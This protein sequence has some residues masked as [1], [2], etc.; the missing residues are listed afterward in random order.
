MNIPTF[1][2]TPA[3]SD[4]DTQLK[5]H[6]D[7]K[8]KP[9]GALG[10]LESIA[11]KIGRIQHTLTPTLRNPHIVVFAG[12]HGISNSGVS[13]Y[14]QEVT[15]QMV[16]NFL[17]NGAAIN[18][19]TNQ[20]NIDFTV[21]DAGVN[22]DFGT[23]SDTRFVSKK[24]G[25]GTHNY[26]ETPAMSKNELA[27]A[28][29]AGAEI[30][31]RIHK[32]GTNIIGFGEMGIG[33]TSS[34]SLLM[35]SLLQLPLKQCVGAGT[36]LDTIGIQKKRAI[37]QTVLDVHSLTTRDP[38]NIMQIVGGYE[39]AMMLGA[40]LKAGELKMLILVDGFIASATFLCAKLLSPAILDYALFTHCSNE[41]GHALLL[42]ECAQTPILDLQLRLGEGTGCALSYPI[43]DSSIRFFNEMASFESAKIYK[44]IDEERT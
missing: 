11:F 41:S 16:L 33:N 23:I 25:M 14:P 27:R 9:I 7:N 3:L 43:I 6:I 40:F 8:T 30:C 44:K 39:L 18:V 15:F 19:F 4:L 10:Y 5:Q 13:A 2:I 34:A 20:H 24:I 1:N 36:G 17:N 38:L 22:H 26:L 37:L 12:D 42:E 21:V 29:A 35:S 32:K 31:A 28:I